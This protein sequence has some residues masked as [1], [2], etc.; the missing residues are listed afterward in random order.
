MSGKTKL[1]KPYEE[2]TFEA[3]KAFPI[4]ERE[5][6]I[7]VIERITLNQGNVGIG[8]IPVSLVSISN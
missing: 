2:L 8:I 3:T 5:P 1:I 6:R 7:V 4:I